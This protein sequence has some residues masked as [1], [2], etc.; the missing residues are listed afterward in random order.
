MSRAPRSSVPA[1]VTVA[2]PGEAKRVLFFDFIEKSNQTQSAD[3]VFDL[4]RQTVSEYGFD[5]I[6]FAATTLPAQEALS[7]EDLNPVVAL[8]FPNDWVDHYFKND[9]QSFDPIMQLSPHSSEI[10]EWD[11]LI[12]HGQLT[13]K[14]KR[15]MLESRE[16]GLNNGISIPIHGPNGESYVA[17]LAT[18]LT[19]RDGR[20]DLT[21]LQIAACQFHIAYSR[22]CRQIEARID[23]VRLTDREREC[24]MWTARGKSAWAISKIIGVS[25]HTVNFHLKSVMRKLKTANRIQAVAL[26]VRLGLINP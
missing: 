11:Q 24:L 1:T 12:Q 10:L 2:R 20:R 17:S 18:E 15:L 13:C 22:L 26:A 16:A 9:Y 7:R 6:A 25:E 23:R 19:V 5:R 3:E 4:F 14:Q 21:N 8:N